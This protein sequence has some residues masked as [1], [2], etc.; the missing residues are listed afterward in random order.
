MNTQINITLRRYKWLG[1][2]GIITICGLLFC[3]IAATSASPD[4]LTFLRK[5]SIELD[6]GNYEEAIRFAQNGLNSDRLLPFDK[7]LYLRQIGLIYQKQNSWSGAEI[8][9]HRALR[10]CDSTDAPVVTLDSLKV[11]LLLGLGSLHLMYTAQYNQ[12]LEYIIAGVKISEAVGDTSLM[13]KSYRLLGYV[14]RLLKDYTSSARYNHLAID[15]AVSVHDTLG[16]VY[17]LNELANVKVLTGKDLDTSMLLYNEALDYAVGAGDKYCIAFIHND[18]GNLFFTMGDY[19]KALPYL[20]FAFNLNLEIEKY[21]EVCIGA[22]NIASCFFELGVFDS[23]SIYLD[24]GMKIAELYSLRSEK[25]LLYQTMGQLRAAM[26]DYKGAYQFQLDYM[27]LHDSIY[28]AEKERLIAEITSKYETEKKE[29][30]NRLLRQQNTIHQLQAE[31]ANANLRFVIIA[32]GLFVIFITGFVWLLLRSNNARK[33]TNEILKKKNLQINQ[34]KDQL[35]ETLHHLSQ[36]ER[37]LEEANAT[38]DRFFSIIAHDLKNP[39]SGI[40]GLSKILNDDFDSLTKADQ[41]HYIGYINESS[42]QLYKLLDNLLQW[43]RTQLNQIDPKPEQ[44]AIGGLINN[45]VLLY[46]NIALNKNIRIEY[47]PACSLFAHA[48]QGM[49]ETIMRNLL[50]NAIKF[51]PEGGVI[52][53]IVSKVEKEVEIIISDSGIGM[54]DEE[55]KKLFKI[56]GRLQK[57]GTASEHGSGLGLIICKEFVERNHGSIQLRSREGEGSQFSVILPEGL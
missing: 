53:I 15:L 43:A 27:S 45:C 49:F 55:Q 23:T 42:D 44:V 37:K 36:R 14:H 35:V 39:F 17:L 31:K 30:E 2:A 50:S 12:A 54:S 11:E 13:I 56:D 5:S 20:R 18:I 32:A 26:S 16:L 47:D 52:K 21:R 9:F 8:Y 41:R 48:D 29:K 51:T 46:K 33:K 38:K 7:I 1:I 25:L 28:N 19:N 22:L 24:K 10:L 6:K 3:P 57:N 40:L 34:Q 4:S